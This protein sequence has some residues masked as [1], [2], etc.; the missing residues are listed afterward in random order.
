MFLPS[1]RI[2]W[3]WER[4][5]E[6]AARKISR[7]SRFAAWRWV[8]RRIGHRTWVHDA[9]GGWATASG[10]LAH[11]VDPGPGWTEEL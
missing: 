1:G 5:L 3:P 2:G 7:L 6:V 10:R 4:W 11:L 8:L 9:P